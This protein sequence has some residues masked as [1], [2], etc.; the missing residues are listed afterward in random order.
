MSD[1]PSTEAKSGLRPQILITK[2]L[3]LTTAVK[4]FRNVLY[5]HTTHNGTFYSH[6]HPRRHQNRYFFETA[7]E[8]RV[9]LIENND[10]LRFNI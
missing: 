1:I 10:E 2:Y 7:V 6:H 8:T 4:S 5:L 9:F 3:K